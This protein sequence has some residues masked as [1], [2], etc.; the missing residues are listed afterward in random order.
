LKKVHNKYEE[1]IGTKVVA[2]HEVKHEFIIEIIMTMVI[3]GEYKGR[4]PLPYTL[5]YMQD[6]NNYEQKKRKRLKFSKIDLLQ[7]DSNN[8]KV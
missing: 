6:Q 7:G 5:M 4:Y 2:N 8:Q 1:T 3:C